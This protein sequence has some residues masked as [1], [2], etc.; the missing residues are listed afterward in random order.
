MRKSAVLTLITMLAMAATGATSSADAKPAGA[1]KT[2][3]GT[4]QPYLQYQFNDVTISNSRTG[5]S[6]PT[7]TARPGGTSRSR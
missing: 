1:K 6:T 2:S 7:S 5:P 4:Q 3:K